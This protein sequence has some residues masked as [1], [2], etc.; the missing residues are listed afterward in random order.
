[1]KEAATIASSHQDYQAIEA[2][3]VGNPDLERLEMLL[4]QFN[5][6]E[7]MGVTWQEARHSDLLAFLLNPQ[8]NHRLGDL[9]VRRLLQR[10]LLSN[11]EHR[12]PIT[13]ID[14]D[15][16][17]M[18]QLIVL[19][20]SQRIDILMI[21]ER[22]RLTVI[23]NNHLTGQVSAQQLARAWEVVQQQYPG[24]DII[25]IYL[26]PDRELPPDDRYLPLD[27][28]EIAT[29]LEELVRSRS[30]TLATDV[31]I[32][33]THYIEA[34]RRHIVGDSEITKLCRRIYGRHQRAFDLIYE[35]RLDRQKAIRN[36]TK[37]LIEQKQ[38][39]VLDHAQE[40]YVGFGV[41]EW[42][43]P[44]LMSWGSERG[45]RPGRSLVFEFD[46]WQETLPLRLHLGP[47]SPHLRQRLLDVASAHQPPFKLGETAPS[48]Y[49]WT[50]IFERQFLT[51]EFYEEAS[52]DELA[53]RI[54]QHWNDF[55]KNDLSQMDSI[56]KEQ[57][58]I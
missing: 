19:R 12:T 21:D 4:D 58:F 34:L 20:D 32:M 48:T 55:L 44:A 54:L 37:L 53:D 16:W 14:L 35:H 9:F 5:I 26:T 13:P 45:G 41:Q 52:T 33:M 51:A 31:R 43:V 18:H 2:L 30:A 7:A 23:L 46:T 17:D 38:G 47:C 36:V 11:S 24:W 49:G 50:T 56:L 57:Q 6:F 22:H 42:D 3:V 10:A 28:G 27:Y 29:L 1:M 39:L 8:Q 15:V 25:G 40:R